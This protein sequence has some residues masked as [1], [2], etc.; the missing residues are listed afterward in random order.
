VRLRGE[1]AFEALAAR[2]DFLPVFL[3]ACKPHQEELVL[4][5][6]RVAE[7]LVLRLQLVGIKSRLLH[8][9]DEVRNGRDLEE[10]P[11]AFSGTFDE[12]GG[13]YAEPLREDVERPERR[14]HAP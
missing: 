9:A 8:V 10:E 11:S 2:V 3:P 1:E 6:F 12:K 5:L 4:D 14:D 13:G 7:V